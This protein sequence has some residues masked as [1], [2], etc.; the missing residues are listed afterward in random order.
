LMTQIIKQ[1]FPN[2][3]DGIFKHYQFSSDELD[4]MLLTNKYFAHFI[5][6]SQKN[7]SDDCIMNNMSGLNLRLLAANPYLS[8]EYGLSIF[9]KLYKELLSFHS[10]SY[11]EAARTL[12]TLFEHNKNFLANDVD[13]II[14]RLTS[15][16]RVGN[17]SIVADLLK[18]QP[19]TSAMMNKIISENKGVFVFSLM[20]N[21]HLDNETRK[22]L[23]TQ[24]NFGRAYSSSTYELENFARNICSLA[25]DKDMIVFLLSHNSNLFSKQLIEKI[26]GLDQS[27]LLQIYLQNSN[28]TVREA[29]VKTLR[30]D[31]NFEE[32]LNRLNFTAL[33]DEKLQLK[34]IHKAIRGYA[35]KVLKTDE[36]TVL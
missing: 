18:Y 19:V 28:G 30:K 31:K 1:T 4:Q 16:D 15:R 20:Q 25:V 5:L 29:V 35:K 36:M 32:Y 26:E 34:I 10:A 12:N 6:P 3:P 7:L 33:R 14:V 21:P 9:E 2:V 22:K 17:F 8:R 11:Q 27:D 13:E 23:L 24:S